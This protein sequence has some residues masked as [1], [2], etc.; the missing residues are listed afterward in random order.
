M[1]LLAGGAALVSPAAVSLNWQIAQFLS[2]IQFF[3][4][5]EKLKKFDD[6]DMDEIRRKDVELKNLFNSG[7]SI[8]KPEL[9][10]EFDETNGDI[11]VKDEPVYL[12]NESQRNFNANYT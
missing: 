11:K 3:L 7:Q 10:F 12:K 2:V 1:P 8:V 5:R 6:L 9:Q 4:V